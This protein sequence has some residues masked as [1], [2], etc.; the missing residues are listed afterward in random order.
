MNHSN[1]KPRKM[2]SRCRDRQ[3]KLK[4]R[5]FAASSGAAIF[6]GVSAAVAF[7]PNGISDILGKVGGVTNR[8]TGIFDKLG[9]DT[10]ALGEFAALIEDTNQFV[11]EAN[12]YLS[13]AKAFYWAITEGDFWGILNGIETAVGLLGLPDPD[14]TAAAIYAQDGDPKTVDAA[15][16]QIVYGIATS[17]LGKT[18]Q[19]RQAALQTQADALTQQAWT[20][21]AES[22][23]KN[24]TQ[25]VMKD[26]NKILATGVQIERMQ[27][28]Q[29]FELQ[30]GQA[31]TNL[32]LENIN[33]EVATINYA[34]ARERENQAAQIAQTGQLVYIPGLKF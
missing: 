28:A 24:V 19:Q 34:R 29:L 8:A 2:K 9:I 6:I 30:V 13:Q 33:G 12:F 15:N 16:R 27:S 23:S 25:D 20:V 4:I 26:G 21:A 3:F 11:G 18:G 32:A 5:L 14:A 17:V 7:D 22:Q 10:S 1:L 31:A